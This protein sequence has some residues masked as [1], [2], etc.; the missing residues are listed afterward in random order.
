MFDQVDAY[1]RPRSIREAIRLLR[2]GGSRAR[3]VAGGTDIAVQADPS[4]RSLVDITRLPLS[5]IRKAGGVFSIGA[6]TTMAEIEDSA[7]LGGLAGG[8]LVRAAAACGSVQLRNMATLGGNLA[9]ASPAADA[10]APLLALGA[11]VVLAGGTRRRT[12]PLGEFFRAPHQTALARELLVEIVVP[13]PPRGARWGWAFLKLG[14]TLSDIAVVSVAA[15]LQ[16]DGRGTVKAAR[17]ALG[18][19]APVPLRFGG[20][21]AILAGQRLTAARIDEAAGQVAREVSPVDDVRAPAAYRRD[22]AR[23]LTGRALGECAQQA[24]VTP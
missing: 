6:T 7:A 23:V 10:A 17:I 2:N 13:I 11:S 5:Y 15:G 9:N 21:E 20:G 24:G 14:R 22:M 16:V 19:V 12:L 3:I 1:H 8:I 18:A 4:I